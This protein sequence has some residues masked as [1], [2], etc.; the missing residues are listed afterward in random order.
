MY[1]YIYIYIYTYG[2]NYQSNSFVKWNIKGSQAIN[3][4]IISI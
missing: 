1:I 3:I 4:D 2:V